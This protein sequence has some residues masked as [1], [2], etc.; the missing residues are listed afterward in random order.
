MH[1]ASAPSRS[2]RRPRT[3]QRRA[4]MPVLILLACVTA[5]GCAA[6]T[7]SHGTAAP[8]HPAVASKAGQHAAGRAAAGRTTASKATRA[9]H[10]AHRTAARLAAAGTPVPGAPGCPMFPADNVWNTDISRLPVSPHSAAW[11]RSMDST[12]TFLH[13]DFGPD[14][15]GYPYGMPYRVVTSRVHRTLVHF[16]YAS[17]SNRGPY[18]FTSRTPIEGGRHA[19]GDRHAIMVNSGTCTLYELFGAHWSKRRPTAGSGAIWNL[20]SNALRPAGWTSADAAGLPILP[21]LLTYGQVRAAVRTGRPI[22]HAI[23]FTVQRTQAA[24]VWP[25]RHE[26]SS[27][28]NGNLPPMG[29][30]FRLKAS[31]R[32]ARFCR[33]ATRYCRDAKAVLTEMR[34]YGLIVADNGSNWFFGGSAFPQWPDALVSLLKGIPAR[35]FQ[36]VNESC[37]MVSRNSGEARGGPLCPVG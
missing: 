29:A 19:T 36:A 5:A 1:P 34:H 10:A 22:T 9:R 3:C 25:A 18:P 30:R 7:P 2:R 32:I 13:P 16:R 26:A 28:H 21:G 14:P 4:A 8:R 17:E 15:G 11:L 24:F 6:Q 31:F 37:L 33:D 35:A 27:S 20:R 23:R 12:R